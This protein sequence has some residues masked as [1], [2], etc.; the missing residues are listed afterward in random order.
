MIEYY[1]NR[2]ETLHFNLSYLQK[3]LAK[4]LYVCHPTTFPFGLVQL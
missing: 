4:N 1:L 3:Q 2:G